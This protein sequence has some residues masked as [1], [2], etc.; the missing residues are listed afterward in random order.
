MFFNCNFGYYNMPMANIMQYVNEDNKNKI[1][2]IKK[3]MIQELPN[4]LPS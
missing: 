2:I 1:N 4:F 3:T